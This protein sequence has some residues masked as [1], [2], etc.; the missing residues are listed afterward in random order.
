MHETENKPNCD[1]RG[2]AG[3]E[4]LTHFAPSPERLAA[5]STA[6]SRAVVKL[7]AAQSIG[8][9]PLALV[10]HNGESILAGA[11][12]V[13]AIAS[14]SQAIRFRFG[15]RAKLVEVDTHVLN[16]AIT[17]AY[18]ADGLAL[19][20][21]LSESNSSDAGNS[22][23]EPSKI[24]WMPENSG[25]ARVFSE[26]V[27]HGVARGASDIFLTPGEERCTVSFKVNGEL[28]RWDGKPIARGFHAQLVRRAKVLSRLDPTVTAIPQDGSFEGAG[29]LRARVSTLPTI[30]G[31]N[32]V[33]RLVSGRV[34]DIDSLGLDVV[35]RE[36]LERWIST[37]G[38][39][40]VFG[41]PTGAGKSASLY[42]VLGELVRRG[43]AI[44]TVE[45]PVEQRIVGANQSEVP[46][47]KSFS[48][49]IRAVLRQAPDVI[50]VGEVRDS[51]TALALIEAAT[52]GHLVLCSIHAGGMSQLISRFNHFGVTAALLCSV[53]RGAL[54]QRLLPRLCGQC[55]VVDL[56][57]GGYREVGCAACG[58]SGYDGRVLV[59]ESYEH[60]NGSP[61]LELNTPYLITF[62]QHLQ[63]LVRFGVISTKTAALV[64]W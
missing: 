38:G 28:H 29:G 21:A 9:L 40:V 63:E 1:H 18:K 14:A 10:E 33:V 12:G 36:R 44:T 48:T 54:V 47:G 23:T 61:A 3:R 52:T 56:S 60:R 51:E 34:R 39:L 41:G 5:C 35:S 2:A 17:I 30:H 16:E 27:E 11:V 4:V 6:K 26:L 53:L 59:V 42:A 50:A 22:R 45:D 58:R 43:I 49:M 57:C 20:G 62:D 25:A 7:D 55:K 37:L 24:L 8:L 13:G 19:V 46:P 64:R 15:L 32:V 31:E